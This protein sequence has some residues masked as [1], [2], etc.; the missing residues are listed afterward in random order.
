MKALCGLGL[1]EGVSAKA[2]LRGWAS[3]GEANFGVWCGDLGGEE[4][5]GGGKFA[6]GDG[7]EGVGG[8]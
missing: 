1:R 5:E 8:E 7:K 6:D 2:M 3:V 4:V